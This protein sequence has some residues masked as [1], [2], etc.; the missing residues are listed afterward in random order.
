M[1]KS[2]LM[3]RKTNGKNALIGRLQRGSWVASHATAPH[4]KY[5]PLLLGVGTKNELYI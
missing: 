3:S 2:D 5:G 4:L 1:I